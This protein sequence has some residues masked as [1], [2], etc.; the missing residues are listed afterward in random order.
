L[1]V[2]I[3][4][5]AKG[6]SNT[7]FVIFGLFMLAAILV[8]MMQ[9]RAGKPAAFADGTTFEQ[10]VEQSWETGKPVLIL[11]TADWCRPCQHLKTT[12]LSDE[13]VEAAIRERTIPVYLDLTN[14]SG[15]TAEAQ[16]AKQMNISAL[17]TLVLWQTNGEISRREG[18]MP[19]VDML[20]WLER[21]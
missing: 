2:L 7:G 16:V 14:Q 8:I 6:S 19:A 12:T 1:E 21:Y 3:Q 10:A 9:P 11:A 13:R 5:M 20:S 18:V 4:A 17:P 15:R